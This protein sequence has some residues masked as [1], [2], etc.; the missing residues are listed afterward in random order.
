MRHC[1]ARPVLCVGVAGLS[2]FS[3]LLY[4]RD[5][6]IC[7]DNKGAEHATQKG[8][9]LS[10]E[11]HA[12]WCDVLTHGRHSQSFRSYVHCALPLADDCTPPL[13]HLGGTSADKRT[14]CGPAV[15]VWRALLGILALAGLGFACRG[16]HTPFCF[17]RVQRGGR[18]SSTRLSSSRKPGNPCLFKECL[19]RS[20]G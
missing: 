12:H 8:I 18:P 3:E 20:P 7:S 1:I 6:V 16:S 15:E 5:V 4:D 19:I 2:T 10:H 9:E 17:E 11:W 14:Y 13:L